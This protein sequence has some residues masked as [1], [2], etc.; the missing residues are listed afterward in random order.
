MTILIGKMV[1]SCSTLTTQTSL[2]K[3]EDSHSPTPVYILLFFQLSLRV[4]IGF[5]AK[6]VDFHSLCHDYLVT[7]G[8]MSMVMAFVTWSDQSYEVA[9]QLIRWH[10]TL[11]VCLWTCRKTI[12]CSKSH[13]LVG[14]IL[15]SEFWQRN[16]NNILQHDKVFCL[17]CVQNWTTFPGFVICITRDCSIIRWNVHGLVPCIIH[18]FYIYTRGVLYKCNRLESHN[19]L[20]IFYLLDLNQQNQSSKSR[21]LRPREVAHPMVLKVQKW[22][23]SPFISI[24]KFLTEGKFWGIQWSVSAVIVLQ[25]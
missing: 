21:T 19:L 25:S 8:D 16:D 22:L 5:I 24:L 1:V 12:G 2:K 10:G 14:E 4:V 18:V 9:V 3:H 11:H 17:F 7:Q 6:F 20:V 15:S 23:F 13:P